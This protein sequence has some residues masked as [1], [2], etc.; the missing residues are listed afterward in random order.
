MVK[1]MAPYITLCVIKM[2]KRVFPWTINNAPFKVIK[3]RINNLYY[4][5]CGTR[6]S[7]NAVLSKCKIFEMNCFFQLLNIMQ[8]VAIIISLETRC[9]M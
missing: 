6:L 9:T 4:D 1:H 7:F 8:I 2:I 3:K 5:C